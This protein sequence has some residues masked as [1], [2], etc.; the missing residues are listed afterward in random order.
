MTLYKVL[1]G[2][3]SAQQRQHEWSMP[4]QAAD[5]TWTPGEWS[6]IGGPIVK[7][8]SGL[9]GTDEP[10]RWWVDGAECY[11][12]ESEGVVGSLDDDLDRKIVCRRMRLLRR[13]TDAEL[14]ALNIYRDGQRT[15]TSGIVIVERRATVEAW[16]SAAVRAS[17]SAAVRASGSATVEASGSATV[18]A[19]G[20]ATVEAWGS[21][22]VRASGS[23][24]VEAWGSAT[25]EASGSAAVRAWGSAAVRASGSAT[26]RASGSA[27][28]E[29]SGSATVEAYKKAVVISEWGSARIS[30]HDAA[31]HVDRSGDRPVVRV[32]TVTS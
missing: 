26:V 14:A 11:A 9:H 19:S 30:L 6:E 1:V 12:V 28:V 16:G 22:A 15:V 29:A 4:V 25:V 3:K 18:E 17:G 5:G 8:Q 20:S 2:S 31:V 21:A 10:A 32:A 27:A 7:C 13:L 23:A 24:T